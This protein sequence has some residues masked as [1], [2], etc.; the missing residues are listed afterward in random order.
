QLQKISLPNAYSNAEA[1]YH[2]FLWWDPTKLAMIPVTSRGGNIGPSSATNPFVG[3]VGFTVDANGINELGHVINPP[4]SGTGIPLC[5][6]V[7]PGRVPDPGGVSVPGPTV[8][9]EPSD[10]A[11]LEACRR[12]GQCTAGPTGVAGGV[13]PST[14]FAPTTTTTVGP[15][16]C[17]AA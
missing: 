5:P 2:A 4:T 12:T 17:F 3:A 8:T 9:T 15:I 1:D 7:G 13:A 16:E 6:P 14:T 10:P 11:V